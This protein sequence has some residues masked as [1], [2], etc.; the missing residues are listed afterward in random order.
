MTLKIHGKKARWLRENEVVQEGDFV[1]QSRVI[2][3]CPEG[4]PPK[5][6]RRWLGA[7]HFASPSFHPVSHHYV[8]MK[9]SA[10]GGDFC[11]SLKIAR[12]TEVKPPNNKL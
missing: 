8:G 2:L 7:L 10:T 1:Y 9:V 5:I 3:F 6:K 12:I 4:P 11:A